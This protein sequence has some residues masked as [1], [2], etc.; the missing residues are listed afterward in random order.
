MES[1]FPTWATWLLISSGVMPT[2][3]KNFAF[4]WSQD[5]VE[6]DNVLS[7]LAEQF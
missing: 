6:A 2:A 5:E 7:L 1:N 4:M 3:L